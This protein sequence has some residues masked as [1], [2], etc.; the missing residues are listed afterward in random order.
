MTDTQI[1]AGI[2]VELGGVVYRLA[3]KHGL[4]LEDVAKRVYLSNAYKR[5]ADPGSL[6]Y[7]EDLLRLVRLFE[8]DLG[9]A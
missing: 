5:L 1:E 9:L 7:K 3:D 6:L 4:P 8:K 2:T